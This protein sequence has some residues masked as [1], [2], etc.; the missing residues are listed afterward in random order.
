MN[1]AQHVAKLKKRIRLQK[2]ASALVLA[3]GVFFATWLAWD[4]YQAGDQATW[5]ALAFGLFLALFGLFGLVY[6]G[7]W[8][9]RAVWVY[10]HV[11]PV[12]MQLRL[13]IKDWSDST[14]YTVYL[15]SG[16]SEEEE[17]DKVMVM[18]PDWPARPVAGKKIP[19]QVYLDPI[20]RKVAVIETEHGLLWNWSAGSETISL[21]KERDDGER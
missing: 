19:C 2:I 21:G 7:R 13:E 17:P 16:E 9:R 3:W 5:I 4:S 6:S 20:S 10:Q 18:N 12:P 14:D 8:S 1:K 11:T 15:F